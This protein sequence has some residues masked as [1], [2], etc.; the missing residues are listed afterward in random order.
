MADT[1]NFSLPYLAVQQ[2]NKEIVHNEALAIIDAS[3]QLRVQDKDLN[4]PPGSPVDGVAYIVGPSPTGLWSGHANAIA[5]Y[6]SELGQW[7][8][9]TPKSGYRAYV[10]DES[11]FYQFSGSAWIGGVASNASATDTVTASTTQTQVGATAINTQVARLT[12]VANTGDSVRINYAATPGASVEIRN[13][14]ANAAWIWPFTGGIIDG[15][16][17]NARDANSLAAGATRRY[18]SFTAGTWRTV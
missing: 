13:D 6:F 1:T 9:I 5:L 4:T 8:F 3:L 14:G 12:T 10:V 15:G 18:R 2:A 17:A 7:I 16:A 11:I